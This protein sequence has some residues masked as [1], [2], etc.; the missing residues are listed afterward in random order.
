MGLGS[1]LKKAKEIIEVQLEARRLKGFKKADEQRK[2]NDY[3]KR[4]AELEV[5]GRE[6]TVDERA[7]YSKYR[8]ERKEMFRQRRANAKKVLKRLADEGKK[9]GER[10][11]ERQSSLT[12]KNPFG[13]NWAKE[14]E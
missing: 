14:L 7:E 3:V 11:K 1:F 6:L 8:E 10:E 9:F 5:Y 12:D 13:L 4:K 2:E